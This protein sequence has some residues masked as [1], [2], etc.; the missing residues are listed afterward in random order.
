MGRGD[1]AVPDGY[2][3]AVVGVAHAVVAAVGAARAGAG[4]GAGARAFPSR[5][6]STSVASQPARCAAADRSTLLPSS[7]RVGCAMNAARTMASAC[8][9]AK[10]ASYAR[11]LTPPCSM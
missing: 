10:P 4:A 7:G 9:G 3:D 1:A 6:R 11:P 5:A 8:P 2:L